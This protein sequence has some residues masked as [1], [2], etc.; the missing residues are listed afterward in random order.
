MLMKFSVKNKVV[1]GV[2]A[3]VGLGAWTTAGGP[4]PV[5]VNGAWQ[6]ARAAE[7]RRTAPEKIAAARMALREWRTRLEL[8]FADAGDA[9]PHERVFKRLAIAEDTCS[10][11]EKNL[12][13]GDNGS[14]LFVERGL[15]DIRLFESYFSAEA[16]CWSVNPQNPA[17][18]PIVIDA[19]AYDVKGDGRTPSLGAFTRAL[20]AA[21]ACGGKPCVVRVPAGS[22]R[23]D[24]VIRSAALNKLTQLP[25]SCLT[26]VVIE[27]AAPDTTELVWGVYDG[28]GGVVENCDNVTLRNFQ[29]RWEKNPFSEG[30]ITAVNV[31]EGS[32]DMIPNPRAKLPDEPCFKGALSCEF[33]SQGKI[34]YPSAFAWLDR[35]RPVRKL[36]NGA[37]RLFF[38]RTQYGN[39]YRKVRL[40]CTICLPDRNDALHSFRIIGGRFVTFDSLWFRNSRA[41]AFSTSSTYQSSATHC[42]IF[43]MDGCVLS[44]CADGY[45]SQSGSYLAHSE[46]AS[47]HDDANN[48]HSNGLY[49][50][51]QIGEDTL[52][53]KGKNGCPKAG[54]LMLLTSPLTGQ[55]IGNVRVKEDGVA[56]NWP[57]EADMLCVRFASLPDGLQTFSSLGL[58]AFTRE[59]QREIVF[60]RKKVDRMPDHIYVPGLGGVG[61]VVTDCRLSSMRNV[62]LPI[63]VPNELVESNVIENVSMG[64]NLTALVQ[65]MEGPPPYHTVVRGNVI[66]GCGLAVHA[67]FQMPNGGAAKN[68]PIHGCRFVG[69]RFENSVRSAL[70]LENLSDCEF[71]G[72]VLTGANS[73][74][75]FRTCENVR[76]SGNVLNGVPLKASD[77]RQTNCQGIIVP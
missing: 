50:F 38:N 5:V 20:D 43:P 26:N 39:S 48:S 14:L 73:G 46:F 66:R 7:I 8:T 24:K 34:D 22:Y 52:V 3:M 23:F 15:E 36:E 51:G 47:M 77:I 27:G 28:N 6:E 19:A 69:N 4:C 74:V 45:Y 37:Y 31:E 30:P 12:A 68:A 55:L 54:D 2:A 67:L 41:A 42:R 76:L 64:V 72:N 65:W 11:V 17:V 40:G 44:L 10:F 71:V 61:S 53:F 13:A 58:K 16:A 32:C 62:A 25:I 33:D 35:E 9:L 29:L 56:T 49:L 63:Q 70:E 1:L 75:S 21:R 18:T 57:G 59:E 60:G